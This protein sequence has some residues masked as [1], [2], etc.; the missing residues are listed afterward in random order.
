MYCIHEIITEAE[1]DNV[2]PG[3]KTLIIVGRQKI[4]WNLECTVSLIFNTVQLEYDYP[5]L[6]C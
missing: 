6:L 5:Y 3:N 1:D 4:Q 2:R